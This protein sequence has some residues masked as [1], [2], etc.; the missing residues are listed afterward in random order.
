MTYNI[1]DRVRIINPV[2]TTYG[3]EGTVTSLYGPYSLFSYDLSV[4]V[5]G[6]P[7]AAAFLTREV[8]P[9]VPDSLYDA[10]VDV[11]DAIKTDE[12][13]LDTDEYAGRIVQ[14]I[15]KNR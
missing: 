2:F 12:R 4:H 7:H 6:T 1:G 13:S 3:R 15:L 9:V 8:A 5:D 14:A 11:I 10:I